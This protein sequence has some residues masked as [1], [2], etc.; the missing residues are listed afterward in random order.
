[1]PFTQCLLKD[2]SLFTWDI[3]WQRNMVLEA[4]PGGSVVKNPPANA[5]DLGSIPGSGWSPEEG[6]GNPL[7]YSCLGNPMDIGAWWA[8]VSGAAQTQTQLSNYTTTNGTGNRL[9]CLELCFS[10]VLGHRYLWIYVPK[11]V[12][13]KVVFSADWGLDWKRFPLR[14]HQTLFLSTCSNSDPTASR[15]VVCPSFSK[16][17]GIVCHICT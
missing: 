4:F 9:W 6:D 2:G 8:T 5:E 13:L 15:R 1:M 10:I 17:Q 11:L 14:F 16:K 12:Q 7:Q 3:F